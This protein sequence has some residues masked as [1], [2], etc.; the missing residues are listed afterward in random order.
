MGIVYQQQGKL[1]DAIAECK[2]AL[3]LKPNF[4]YA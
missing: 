3:S 2:T 4:V 1:D